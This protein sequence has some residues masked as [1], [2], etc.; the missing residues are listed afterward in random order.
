VVAVN[1]STGSV[2]VIDQVLVFGLDLVVEELDDVSDGD[3]AD[4]LV[5]A[6]DGELADLVAGH[7]AHDF[8]DVVVEVAGNGVASHHLMNLAVM[9]PLT[10]A[11]ESSEHVTLSEDAHESALAI[12]DRERADIALNQAL[13][14]L[15]HGRIGTNVDGAATLGLENFTYLHEPASLARRAPRPTEK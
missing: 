3:D 4:E 7:L 11:I 5:V 2:E 6:L 12:D 9:E 15:G 13:D 1:G 8:M 10:V 14:G